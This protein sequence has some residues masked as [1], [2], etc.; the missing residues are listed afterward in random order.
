MPEYK[1]EVEAL[2]RDL[3]RMTITDPYQ[4][5]NLKQ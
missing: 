5:M 2:I 3:P 1:D 4:F